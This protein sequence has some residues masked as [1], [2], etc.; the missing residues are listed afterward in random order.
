M[1]GEAWK[2][3]WWNQ[4][5]APR[6][7]NHLRACPLPRLGEAVNLLQNSTKWIATPPGEIYT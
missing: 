7:L 1:V 2:V 3:G 5:P 4:A 6:P